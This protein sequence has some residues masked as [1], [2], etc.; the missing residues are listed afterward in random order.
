LP[1]TQDKDETTLK[2]LDYRASVFLAGCSCL[3]LACTD[4]ANDDGQ[5]GDS[6]SGADHARGDSAANGDAP[7]H[8]VPLLEGNFSFFVTSIEAMRE[9]SDSADGFGGNL[10]GL[11]GADGICQSIGDGQG[12][13]NKTWRAFLSATTGGPDGGPVHA[14]ERIGDG[15]WYDR[16]GRLV[17]QSPA[18]LV[19]GS[20]PEADVV[21]VDNLPNER[22][23]P[24]NQNDADDHDVMTGSTMEGRLVDTNPARTCQDWTTTE[25]TQDL[26]PAVLG[27]FTFS[28]NGPMCGHSWPGVSGAGWIQAHPAPGC[29]A[30]A[31]LQQLGPPEEGSRAVGGGGGYGAIYCFALTP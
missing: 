5:P 15:P 2:T 8:E 4:A 3:I 29:G 13:W 27:P 25:T 1:Q 14:I 18:A 12:A 9:L 19:A 28:V 6:D 24:L 23:E 30:G 22:G 16:L 20:R 21:I 11:A 31:V 10:G 17:A 7:G 26:E